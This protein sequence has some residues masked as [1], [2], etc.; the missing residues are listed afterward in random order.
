MHIPETVLPGHPQGFGRTNERMPVE[1]YPSLHFLLS[2]LDAGISF[3]GILAKA[4]Y[5]VC[6]FYTTVNSCYHSLTV[7][8]LLNAE[9][10]ISWD[11]IV[12]RIY[13]KVKANIGKN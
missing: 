7:A 2:L 12:F 13:F 6:H 9:H 1:F 10:V 3:A 11:G 8:H 5:T 4:F